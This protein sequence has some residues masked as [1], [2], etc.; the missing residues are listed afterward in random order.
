MCVCVKYLC[1][2]PQKLEE[3]LDPRSW[4][5]RQ[6]LGFLMGLLETELRTFRK[7]ARALK[8]EPSLQPLVMVYCGEGDAQGGPLLTRSKKYSEGVR[9][10]AWRRNVP[11]GEN[12]K[13]KV[14]KADVK[15]TGSRKLQL[16]KGVSEPSRRLRRGRGWHWPGHVAGAAGSV[17]SEEQIL[18]KF[19]K[20][21]IGELI[22]PSMCLTSIY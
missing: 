7:A 1:K 14:P 21:R 22:H 5:Y 20:R 18:W 13:F 16:G 3:A 9:A 12:S 15:Q 4:S 17:V 19:S 11:R 8:C 2:Y 6:S 10:E